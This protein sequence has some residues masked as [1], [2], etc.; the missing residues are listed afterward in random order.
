MYVYM[1]IRGTCRVF[2]GGLG[3]DCTTLSSSL[4]FSF[5]SPLLFFSL[6][7]FPPSYFRYPSTFPFP[8]S[9]TLFSFPPTLFFSLGSFHL[10]TFA[11]PL[12]SL[13]SFSHTLFLS[14]SPFLYAPYTFFSLPPGIFFTFFTF[15]SKE[16]T[17]IPFPLK[18]WYALSPFYWIFPC[19]SVLPSPSPIPLAI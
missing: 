7:S 15:V 1:Y 5:S 2:M 9:H 14:P 19:I 6:G 13:S 16:C 17:F 8:P 3:S 11:I 18:N 4:L 10:F 12:L